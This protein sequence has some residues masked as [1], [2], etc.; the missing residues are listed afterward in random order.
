MKYEVR[1][2]QFLTMM[3]DGADSA[4]LDLGPGQRI[5]R[6]LDADY[7]D[8]RKPVLVVNAIIEIDDG[9]KDGVTV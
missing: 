1:T 2:L 4:V 6:L 8:P 3:A 5:F 9:L 7:L